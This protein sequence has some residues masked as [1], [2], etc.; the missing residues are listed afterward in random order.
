MVVTYDIATTDGAGRRRLY[1]VA[2]ICGRWGT[3]VQHSV[4]ECE[5]DASEYRKLEEELTE[6]ICSSTDNIRIYLLG[7]RFQSRVVTLGCAR[8]ASALERYIL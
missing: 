4:Y 5:V 8:T 1:R 2:K 6:A 7:N 3:A